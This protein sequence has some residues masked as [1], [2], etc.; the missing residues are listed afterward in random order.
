MP[1]RLRID[2]N[3]SD[4]IIY[5]LST[6]LKDYKLCWLIN[7]QLNL[8]FK[9]YVDLEINEEI[10][11]K[12]SLYIDKTYE[13]LDIYIISN[14]DNNI[15]WFEKAKHFHYFFIIYG[16]PL[17]STILKFEKELKKIESILLVTTL[18]SEEK[19]LAIPLLSNLELHITEETYKEKSE[20]KK[21]LPKSMG[22]NKLRKIE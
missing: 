19:K 18:S 13:H 11:R 14:T 2:T 1:K 6:H 9:R 12:Y 3:F 17:K 5:G 8:N 21:H 22:I 20:L 10:K 4:Y 7:N 15:P 16:N